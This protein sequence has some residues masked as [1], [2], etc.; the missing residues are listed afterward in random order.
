MAP[1]DMAAHA[2]QTEAREAASDGEPGDDPHG[3]N[4]DQAE[5]DDAADESLDSSSVPQIAST[6]KPTTTPPRLLMTIPYARW[7][8]RSFTLTGPRTIA[9]SRTPAIATPSA[10]SGAMAHR[11]RRKGSFDSTASGTNIGRMTKAINK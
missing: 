8:G 11:R 4:V 5:R 7:Y 1:L 9:A 2:H 10:A 3:D 6:Y